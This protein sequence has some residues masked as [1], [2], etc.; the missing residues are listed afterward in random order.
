MSMKPS[1]SIDM[2]RIAFED[3]ST[4]KKSPIASDISEQ[5]SMLREHYTSTINEVK[6]VVAEHDE[7]LVQ[8]IDRNWDRTVMEKLVVVMV[9]LVLCRLTLPARMVLT[10]PQCLSRTGATDAS[11][12]DASVPRS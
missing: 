11:P 6:A 7:R 4:V 1:R 8:E 10:S 2:K 9:L 5:S 3:C 12:N